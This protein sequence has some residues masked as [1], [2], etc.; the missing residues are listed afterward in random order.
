M[1]AVTLESSVAMVDKFP[2]F[3]E[4]CFCDDLIVG[5]PGIHYQDI[6]TM[7]TQLGQP[8]DQF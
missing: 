8:A 3:P 7:R 4:E 2:K 1:V 5:M 6:V